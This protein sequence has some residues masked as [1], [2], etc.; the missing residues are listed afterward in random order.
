MWA[1]ET[2]L[3][4][5]VYQQTSSRISNHKVLAT[6]L[7][8]AVKKQQADCWEDA[9]EK[10]AVPGLCP[11]AER[12]QTLGTSRPCPNSHGCDTALTCFMEGSMSGETIV[13][14]LAGSIRVSGLPQGF[15][16]PGPRGAQPQQELV[17]GKVSTTPLFYCPQAATVHRACLSP[18]YPPGALC[19]IKEQ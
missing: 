13:S 2:G 4:I 6:A 12:I 1:G 3:R 15:W 11:Q 8:L 16:V 14:Q 7:S 10:A 9:R 17:P 19:W 18:A 5:R